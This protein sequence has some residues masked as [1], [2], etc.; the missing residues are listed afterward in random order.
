MEQSARVEKP[1][2]VG[3]PSCFRPKSRIHCVRTHTL[4]VVR[5]GAPIVASLLLVAMPGAPIVAFLLLNYIP[6]ATRP[7]ALREPR[8]RR[9]RRGPTMSHLLGGR[10]EVIG[11]KGL[12]PALLVVAA[13]W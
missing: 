5:P 9:N 8:S 2:S 6:L 4:L 13:R 12:H 11:Q 7:G 1:L 3:A 10:G